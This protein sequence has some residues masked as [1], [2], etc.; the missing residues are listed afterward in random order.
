M[1]KTLDRKI[2]NI[3]ELL[4]DVAEKV[5]TSIDRNAHRIDNLLSRLNNQ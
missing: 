3:V 5:I 1:I 2:N 4:N